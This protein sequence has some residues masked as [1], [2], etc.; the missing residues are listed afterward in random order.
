MP[1][2]NINGISGLTL[3]TP[4]LYEDERGH[5]F[6]SYDSLKFREEISSDEYLKNVFK[7]K[8]FVLDTFS[9]SR[10]P[11][12]RGLHGVTNEGSLGDNAT[13]NLG[14]WLHVYMVKYTSLL[15]SHHL[16]NG[17]NFI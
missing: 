2:F 8:E 1:E 5:N 3:F 4:T 10:W 12:F 15:R 6:E 7:E 13:I 11:V 14:N 16:K 17:L 9:K